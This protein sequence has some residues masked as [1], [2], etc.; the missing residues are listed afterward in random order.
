MGALFPQRSR[1]L[2]IYLAN[3]C[4][5]GV[6][7]QWY[8]Y[9]R[10]KRQLIQVQKPFVNLFRFH[11]GSVL[12]CALLT[13]TLYVFDYILDFILVIIFDNSEH[14]LSQRSRQP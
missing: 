14:G 7:T 11:W 4:V 9:R 13:A 6:A 8:F 3:F 5:S 1:Y 12:G 2:S 10:E